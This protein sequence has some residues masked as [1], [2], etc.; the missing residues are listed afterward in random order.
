MQSGNACPRSIPFPP[1]QSKC[2]PQK[3]KYLISRSLPRA[4]FR[5]LRLPICV[6]LHPVDLS[7]PVLP[8]AKRL[9]RAL[10]ELSGSFARDRTRFSTCYAP[11]S[12]VK[13]QFPI[14]PGW[15]REHS[16]SALDPIRSC[17]DNSLNLDWIS[18]ELREETLREFLL[19]C[20]NLFR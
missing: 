5:S 6:I 13:C 16:C 12:W 4:I 11:A 19:F 18:G 20:K 7:H 10:T 15:T 2:H 9:D 1:R 17:A 3:R 14:V 8:S